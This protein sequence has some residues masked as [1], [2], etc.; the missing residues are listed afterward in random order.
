MRQMVNYRKVFE[1]HSEMVFVPII[2]FFFD[3]GRVQRIQCA[4]LCT[5]AYSYLLLMLF[6]LIWIE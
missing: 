1:T 3:F 4:Q 2:K 5:R 6:R